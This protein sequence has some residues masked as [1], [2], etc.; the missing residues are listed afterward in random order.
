M[1]GLVEVIWELRLRN[2]ECRGRG[3]FLQPAF[4][5]QNLCQVLMVVV[6]EARYPASHA[7]DLI[8]SPVAGVNGAV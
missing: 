6:V 7:R 2:E 8:V 5:I 3:F 1:R 4:Q